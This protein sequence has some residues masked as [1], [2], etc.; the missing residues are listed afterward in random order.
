[1]TLLTPILGLVLLVTATTAQ[2]LTTGKP[3]I[4]ACGLTCGKGSSPLQQ[5]I[6]ACGGESASN[7][8]IWSC[9]CQSAYLK[10]LYSTPNGIC[11]AFCTDPAQNQQI[12]AWYTGNCGTDLGASE[13][14]EQAGASSAAGAA[15]TTQAT[16][17]A[18]AGTTTTGKPK[19]TGITLTN[20]NGIG[21]HAPADGTYQ[22]PGGW[23]A[24]HY[25]SK[26]NSFGIHY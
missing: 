24:N 23:W 7:Q 11:D 3:A 4:P 14:A 15:P 17:A 22:Q 12:M 18:A 26:S 5:A 16:G 6:T 20:G 21:D 8:Q 9:F 25:V 10:S 2:I 1:M 13:H 19:A